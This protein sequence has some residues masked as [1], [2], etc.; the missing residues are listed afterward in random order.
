MGTE[1]ARPDTV[2]RQTLGDV[3]RRQQEETVHRHRSDWSSTRH[4]HGNDVSQGQGQG[5]K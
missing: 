1:Q 4:I 5:I 3:Q 2:R